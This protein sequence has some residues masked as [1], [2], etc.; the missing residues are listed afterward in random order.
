MWH[1][2]FAA[3]LAIPKRSH[4][5]RGPSHAVS[6][7]PVIRHDHLDLVQ[8][9]A[10]VLQLRHAALDLTLPVLEG[11]GDPDKPLGEPC[12]LGDAL[13]HL[14]LEGGMF[15]LQVEEPQFGKGPAAHGCE[16][17]KTY[18]FETAAQRRKQ[19]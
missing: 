12:L 1:M 15:F 11:F 13:Q 7:V 2:G 9:E 14:L 19:Q 17:R 6:Q 10:L 18:S 5:A 4:G 8:G 3:S 16:Q